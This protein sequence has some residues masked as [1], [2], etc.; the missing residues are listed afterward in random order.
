MGNVLDAVNA[1]YAK[2]VA[3]G[4][5]NQVPQE[6]RMKK[7]FITLLPKGARNAEK[8]IRILPTKDGSSPL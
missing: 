5:R 8:R 1:Q 2:N 6:E 3:S 7:Y 4:N